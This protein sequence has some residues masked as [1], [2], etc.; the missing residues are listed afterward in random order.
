VHSMKISCPLW[1]LDLWLFAQEH[2]NVRRLKTN[3]EEEVV[4][5]RSPTLG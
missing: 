4:G 5:E 1:S 2:M 3:R